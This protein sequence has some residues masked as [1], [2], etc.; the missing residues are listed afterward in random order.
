MSRP[1][2]SPRGPEVERGPQRGIADKGANICAITTSELEF[3]APIDTEYAELAVRTLY[4]LDA[5]GGGA[6]PPRRA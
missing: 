1:R 6:A 2:C 4:G 3:S 5:R